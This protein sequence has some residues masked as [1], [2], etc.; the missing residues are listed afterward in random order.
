MTHAFFKALLFLGAGSVIHGMSEE[1]DIRKMGG[2]A[3]K[4]P[5]THITFLVAC[6]AISG[7]PGLSGFFS[8]DEIL[9][10]VFALQHE[11]HP[12]PGLHIAVWIVGALTAGLTAF[13]MF[14]LYFLTFTGESRA[15]EHVQARIHESP[16]SMTLPLIVLAVL[17]VVSGFLGVPAVISHLFNKDAEWHFLDGFLDQ[18]FV[19]SEG[20]LASR[21]AADHGT[22]V[23]LEWA[24]MGGSVAIGLFGIG[25]AWMLYGRKTDVPSRI[26]SAVPWAHRLVYNKYYVDEIYDVLIVKPLVVFSNILHRVVDEFLID[27]LL[28]DGSA[29][30]VESMGAVGKRLQTGNVQRYAAYIVLGLGAIAY[31]MLFR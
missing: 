9:W 2:L 27:R 22:E 14:R 3:K 5:I 8:K 13:Y 20:V 10:N 28:V 21:Y 1:Q 16:A 26:V 6:L 19:A 17:T 4:M 24:L 11:T 29:W 7:V 15:D 31:L 12:L 18:V 23:V 30:L 25:L